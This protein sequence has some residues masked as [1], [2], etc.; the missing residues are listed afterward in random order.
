MKKTLKT[1]V[2]I[3]SSLLMLGLVL[4][5]FVI[6]SNTQLSTYIQLLYDIPLYDL[7]NVKIYSRGTEGISGTVELYDS[8]NHSVAKIERV[9]KAENLYMSFIC[10]KSNG[11]TVFFP[12]KIY[13]S[14]NT[15][16]S[17]NGGTAAPSLAKYYIKDGNC[18]LFGSNIAPENKR[19]INNIAK[20]VTNGLYTNINDSIYIISID[21]SNCKSDKEYRIVP[22]RA[23]RLHLLAIDE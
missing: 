23:G 9:W 17:G 7:C 15:L 5:G 19:T 21:L 11:G 1:T 6:R 12:Y 14:R 20:K 3:I 16:T 10:I 2:I 4:L 18:V 22:D 13:G 8:D